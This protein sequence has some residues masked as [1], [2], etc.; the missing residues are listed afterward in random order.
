MINRTIVD[1]C[2]LLLGIFWTRIGTET[3][4]AASGTIEEIMRVA[5]AGKPVMLYFSKVPIDPDAL[6]LDQVARLKAFKDRIYANALT[7]SYKSAIDFRDKLAKQLELRVRDLQKAD[8]S[9]QPPPLNLQFVSLESGKLSGN[10]PEKMNLELPEV[11]DSDIQNMFASDEEEEF[12]QQVRITVAGQLER[13]STVPTVIA[14]SNN[15][16][17]GIRNLYIEILIRTIA[18]EIE[19]MDAYPYDATASWNYPLAGASWDYHLMGLL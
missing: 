12:R 14:L 3:G 7:E 13:A 1:Q 19:V 9:G 17:S 2:D 4:D 16:S 5:Q 18:G 15:G 8:S 10:S 6:D 11:S